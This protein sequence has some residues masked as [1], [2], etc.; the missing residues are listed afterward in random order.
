M[1][2]KKLIPFRSKSIIIHPFIDY[3]YQLIYCFYHNH[4]MNGSFI[5]SKSSI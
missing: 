5:L 4:G 1:E 2:F 3:I